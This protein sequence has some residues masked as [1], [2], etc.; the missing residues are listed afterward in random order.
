M[1]LPLI[2]QLSFFLES[3]DGGDLGFFLLTRNIFHATIAYFN[4]VTIKDFV[5]FI[6]TWKMFVKK[7][8]EKDRFC[9]CFDAFVEKG[10]KSYYV[11]LHVLT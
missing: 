2:G 7:K 11:I 1:Q 6:C 8:T 5:Q 10:I 4:C 9:I 3:H